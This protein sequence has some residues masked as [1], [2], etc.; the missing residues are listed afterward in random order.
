MPLQ[1][2]T[3][4]PTNAYK[5]PNKPHFKYYKETTPSLQAVPLSAK[6]GGGGSPEGS[7]PFLQLPHFSEAVI[8]KIACKF[9]D[10]R[11]TEDAIEG[12]DG[13]KFNG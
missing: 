1:S 7:A 9:E 10:V 13:F 4:P 5:Y 6:K 3:K 12:R 2:R 8:K 11:D